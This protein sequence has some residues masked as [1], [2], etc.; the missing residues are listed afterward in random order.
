MGAGG[1]REGPHWAQGQSP[2]DD[3]V[4]VPQPSQPPVSF[5]LEPLQPLAQPSPSGA[6][7]PSWAKATKSQWVPGSC[8]S[9]MTEHVLSLPKQP[10]PSLQRL[11]QNYIFHKG[12][13]TVAD[14]LSFNV[15]RAP[16]T[17]QALFQV[18]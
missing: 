16:F 1:T 12:E 3:F 13:V 17:G 9:T 14:S 4:C 5:S 7:G 2:Q 10:M 18:L 11:V 15:D 6:L 8:H